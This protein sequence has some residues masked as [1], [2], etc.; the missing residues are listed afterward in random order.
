MYVV[1]AVL[2]DERSIHQ[3]KADV[4]KLLAC[5]LDPSAP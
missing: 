5:E 3:F 2:E 4:P 1:A